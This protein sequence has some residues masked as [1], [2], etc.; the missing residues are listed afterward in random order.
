M[1]HKLTQIGIAENVL[2]KVKKK[3]DLSKR[4]IALEKNP[5][6]LYNINPPVRR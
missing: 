5:E 3:K 2:Q 6:M 1:C 4:K